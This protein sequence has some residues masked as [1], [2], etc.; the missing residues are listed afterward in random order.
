MTLI[1]GRGEMKKTF[2]PLLLLLL[3]VIGRGA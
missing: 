1:E 2:K 3:V